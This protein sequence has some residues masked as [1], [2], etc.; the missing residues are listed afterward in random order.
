MH[1]F[2]FKNR[3][4]VYEIN[5]KKSANF[6][7]VLGNRSKTDII[8]AKMLYK[9]HLLLKEDFSIPIID[10][11]TE[12]SGSSIHSY[13]IIRKTRTMLTNHLQ[14]MKYREGVKTKLKESIIF[15]L[16]KV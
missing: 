14:S 10:R 15:F 5:P 2:A 11:T 8:D 4:K 6:A 13:E 1:E 9:F 12:Q 7:K 3:I 16:S